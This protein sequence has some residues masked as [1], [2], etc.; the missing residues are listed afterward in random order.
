MHE[1]PQPGDNLASSRDLIT[2]PRRQ[3]L[4]ALA[5]AGLA[6]GCYLL[7]YRLR[8]DPAQFHEFVPG[9]LRTLP[10]VVFA[11]LAGLWLAGAYR[12]QPSGGRL[13]R[14]LIG[15]VAGTAVGAALV[16]AREGF[17]GLSRV[18]FAV[19][20]FLFVIA[21]IGWRAS[22]VLWPVRRAPDA[23]GSAT[24]LVDRAAERPSLVVTL[25]SLYAYRELLKNLVLKDLKLK[26][27]GSVLG[28]LWSLVN[29]LMMIFVYTLAFKYI[30]RNGVPDFVFLLLLGILAWTFFASSASM[31][32]G[33]IIDSGNLM[34]GVQFPRAILPIATVLFNFVQYLLTVLVFL[35]LMLIVYRVPL[36]APMLLFPVFLALQVVFTIGVALVLAAGTTF[37]RDLR[38]LLEIALSMLF[39]T[40]PIVY[41]LT[42]VPDRF[43][44]A[45]LLSPMSPF[46]IA[47]QQMFYYRTW[48]DLATWM[49]ALAYA[50]SSFALGAVLFLSL[51]DRFGEEI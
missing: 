43:R 8:F 11:Q 46:V 25:G 47:Y 48:P 13:P 36:S 44:V 20:V 45:V 9:A 35:P 37:F 14:L 23:P 19:D 28:F 5:D 22:R 41:P 34:K 21:A 26:Y 29:P 1:Q 50:V 6:A 12:A 10:W 7:A 39:W 31:A 4:T 16:G 33:A 24:D 32:T 49:V 40:T 2:T 38:H 42:M 30:M 15:A 27:R 51:E 18:A 3:G 17:T